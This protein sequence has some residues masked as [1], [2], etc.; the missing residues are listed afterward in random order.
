VWALAFH[1]TQPWLA[2]G[3]DAGLEIWRLDTAPDG[4]VRGGAPLANSQ[5]AEHDSVR[6]LAF[7]P[8]GTMLVVGNDSGSFAIVPTQSWS[9][10][11][12]REMASVFAHPMGI[13]SLA[14]CKGPSAAGLC[15]PNVFASAGNDGNVKLWRV[16]GDEGSP[17]AKSELTLTGPSAEALSVAFS[18][19]GKLI[20]AGD[21]EGQIHLWRR[22][23]RAVVNG[24][25]GALHRNLTR[26]EWSRSVGNAVP[27]ECTCPNLPPAFGI[28]PK[29]AL[30]CSPS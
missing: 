12:W 7:S 30:H 14:F 8:D 11:S 23:L 26:E 3:T 18:P 24:L 27:Y 29:G 6:A 4:Q 5:R 9:S 1:P 22:D 13:T 16:S 10:G 2:I 15:E 28:D 25:C 20:A 17:Q 19:N 21:A